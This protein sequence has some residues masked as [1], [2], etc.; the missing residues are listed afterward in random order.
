MKQLF[1]LSNPHLL[2]F[3]QGGRGF[4]IPEYQRPYA[5]DAE[6]ADKLITDIFE[7]LKRSSKRSTNP[8]TQLTTDAIFLGTVILHD[9]RDIVTGVH[10]DTQNLLM[11]V[12][13]VVDGQ[14]RIFSLAMLAGVLSRRIYGAIAT[15]KEIS[16]P[17]QVLDQLIVGL[18]DALPELQEFYGVDV[19]KTGA[20]P[21]W[22]PRAIRAGDGAARP[23]WDQWTLKGDSNK[24]YRSTTATVLSQFIDSPT[25]QEIKTDDQVDR[26]LEAFQKGIDNEVD[27]ADR[28]FAIAVLNVSADKQSILHNCAPASLTVAS[29]QSLAT[30]TLSAIYCSVILLAT[31]RFLTRSC[32]LVVIECDDLGLAF[33]MFQSLNATGTPLTA[34]EVFKT[35]L[36]KKFALSY[37]KDVKPEVDRIEKVIATESTANGRDKI[38]QQIIVAAAFVY[39]GEEI[40]KRFSEE[41]D[42]FNRTLK[43]QIHNSHTVEFVTCIADQAE[44]CNVVINPPRPKMDAKDAPLLMH[45]NALGLTSEQADSSALCIGFLKDANH[46]L[47]H[48]VLSLFYSKLLRGQGNA[49]VKSNAAAEFHSVCQATAAFFT[50][51]TGGGAR[52]F[53]DAEYRQLFQNTNANISQSMGATN[54]TSQFVKEAYRAA[55]AKKGVYDNSNPASARTT[56]VSCAMKS[57][58]YQKKSVCKFALFSAFHDAAP[59]LTSGNEGLTTN[60][61]PKSA[62]FLSFSRWFAREYEVIEH[63]ATRDEPKQPQF[64]NHFD[65]AVYPGNTMEVDKIGNLTLLSREVN[66]SIYPEWPDKVFYY[67]SLTKPNN[68]ATG[69]SAQALMTKLGITQLPPSLAKL[70]A[71]TNYLPQL[72]PLAYRGVN[73]LKWDLAFINRRSEH[74]CERIFDCLDQWLR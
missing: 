16:S 62:T 46:R 27:D 9:E 44:Y 22:K 6:I 10:S 23:A 24:F 52:G 8:S 47:A 1:Q 74:L 45:L 19:K 30:D 70:T 2:D 43:A 39:N 61:R 55:L 57:P 29:I 69:P 11:K 15:L 26:V 41:R 34:F 71:T 13:N 54:Q 60:G 59:D 40:S 20:T 53:P 21:K 56:W 31:A 72:A 64:M 37:S 5:W 25:T 18:E 32:H 4:Y 63:V 58:W 42:W 66:S 12:S 3:F 50:M 28:D 51:W 38:T 65:S 33:D 35:S 73:G 68:T 14:Q 36:V 48:S 17:Q 7:G 67:W 49:R